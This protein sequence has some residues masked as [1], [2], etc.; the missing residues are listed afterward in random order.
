MCKQHGKLSWGFFWKI[1]FDFLNIFFRK[2]FGIFY[3]LIQCQKKSRALRCVFRTAHEDI[4]NAWGYFS[5]LVFWSIYHSCSGR[6]QFSSLIEFWF[7]LFASHSSLEIST[8][9]IKS[10]ETPNLKISSVV[11]TENP[12]LFWKKNP[13]PCQVVN[14]LPIRYSK[15][16]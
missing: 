4:T 14:R 13:T 11:L 12:S 6:M 7:A 16:F 15:I 9:G 8:C 10:A 3:N 2:F 1:I 5:L